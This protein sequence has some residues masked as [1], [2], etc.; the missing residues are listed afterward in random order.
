MENYNLAL[1]IPE[2]GSETMVIITRIGSTID[3]LSLAVDDRVDLRKRLPL[4]PR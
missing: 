1:H 4:A 2:Y 3:V